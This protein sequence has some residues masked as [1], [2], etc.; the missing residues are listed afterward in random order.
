MGSLIGWKGPS[1]YLEG[2]SVACAVYGTAA[3]W[4]AS[5]VSRRATG[6]WRGTT[7]DWGGGR[8][9]LKARGGGEGAGW[10]LP[11]RFGGPLRREGGG[12]PQ[13]RDPKKQGAW[14]GNGGG[15]GAGEAP[16]VW[17]RSAA[18][19]QN[20]LLDEF[21]K[22]NRQGNKKKTGLFLGGIILKYFE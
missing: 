5:V 15:G 2:V 10:T 3:G 7:G 6:K 12:C 9:P 17:V 21:Y 4:D 1:L 8:L 14:E 16:G 19:P 20:V 11:P 22:K 18:V 13:N